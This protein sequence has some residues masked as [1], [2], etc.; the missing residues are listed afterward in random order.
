MFTYL[1]RLACTAGA[2]II[3]LSVMAG[4]AT[5]QQALT[6]KDIQDRGTVKIGVLVDF[7]PFGVMNE[8]NQPDGYDADVAKA[9]AKKMGVEVELVPV[10]G[11]NRIPYL[12][13]GKIDMVI[14]SLSITPARSEQV[15]FSAPYCALEGVMYARKDLDIKDY[16]D[17]GGLRIGVARSSPQDTLV[18]EH[19]PADTKIQRFDQISAVYQSVLSQQVDGA[20]IGTL[21]AAELDKKVAGS[22]ETKFTLYVTYQGVALRLGSDELAAELNADI[23]ELN[24]EG[25]L[26]E[27]YQKWVGSALPDL[28]AAN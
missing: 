4:A 7:P 19:A 22:Y 13:T 9:L 12:Q 17:L 23:A 11:P 28:T 25:V 6:L 15:L 8:N 14:G 21:I 2:A 26:A 16:T 1:T 20:V 18:T 24:A 3:G 27:F 10:T 5:A